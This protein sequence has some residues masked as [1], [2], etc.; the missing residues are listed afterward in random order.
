MARTPGY[1]DDQDVKSSVKISGRRGGVVWRPWRGKVIVQS[2]PEHTAQSSLDAI[3][4]WTDWLRYM[5][6]IW[7]YSAWQV[8]LSCH[9]LERISGV[10]ARDWFMSFARG[11]IFSF[12]MPTGE[13]IF[14]VA[15]RDKYSR[16]LDVF[17]QERGSL[18]LRGTDAWETLTPGSSGDVLTV[19]EGMPRWISPSGLGGGV[20]WLSAT[21]LRGYN[22]AVGYILTYVPALGLSQTGTTG[23]TTVILRSQLTAEWVPSTVRMFV[24]APGNAAGGVKLF[25][26]TRAL[27]LEGEPV[28]MGRDSVVVNLVA[29]ARKWFSVDV[30]VLTAGQPAV[31]YAL[32]IGRAADDSEDTCGVALNLLG[33]Q[34][35]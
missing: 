22:S 14:S 8:R 15:T 23:G 29:G 19:S 13:E 33:V 18:L 2:L 26:E 28:V 6:V 1:P 35:A 30:S 27:P 4:P 5:N 34:V 11:H 12:V 7:H 21:E 31:G 10:P 9:Y 24:H 25:A 3:A 17:G 16:S 20:L 32:L